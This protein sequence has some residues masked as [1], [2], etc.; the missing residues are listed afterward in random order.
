MGTSQLTAWRLFAADISHLARNSVVTP[1]VA[2]QKSE[3]LP[4]AREARRFCDAN[5]TMS[6]S[7][8]C[9]GKLHLDALANKAGGRGRYSRMNRCMKRAKPGLDGGERRGGG[10][11][12]VARL[13][14]RSARSLVQK[15]W[16]PQ[17]PA[18]A[19]AIGQQ[20]LFKRES[21]QIT[22]IPSTCLLY[23][24]AWLYSTRLVSSRKT[25]THWLDHGCCARLSRLLLGSTCATSV[26][27][28]VF[29]R[30]PLWI[31]QVQSLSYHLLIDFRTICM[32]V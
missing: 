17:V 14:L 29:C 4:T 28:T 24:A 6:L 22:T 10:L 2:Q 32:S 1:T 23:F 27:R 30:I 11:A 25:Q 5:M 31:L 19:R 9:N 18:F 7:I 15:R 8:S 26:S 16:T 13:S 20:G 12:E 21:K 3:I